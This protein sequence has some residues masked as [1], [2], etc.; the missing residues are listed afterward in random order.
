VK[1][2]VFGEPGSARIVVFLQNP[3]SRQVLGIAQARL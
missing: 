3:G 2:T 1:F